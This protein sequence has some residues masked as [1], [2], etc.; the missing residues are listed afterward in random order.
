M[1]LSAT[2]NCQ[3][4]F[5]FNILFECIFFAYYNSKN[6]VKC[7]FWVHLRKR[8]FL[9]G[10]RYFLVIFWKY[11][12][13]PIL[14]PM[15]SPPTSIWFRFLFPNRWFW[16]KVRIVGY[17]MKGLFLRVCKFLRKNCIRCRSIW[18]WRFQMPQITPIGILV[19]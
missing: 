5:F 19:K 11:H 7:V 13:R 12:L 6:F 16:Q 9:W 4:D 2:W 14:R 8:M 3:H 15:S 1:K 18:S 10:I 17:R